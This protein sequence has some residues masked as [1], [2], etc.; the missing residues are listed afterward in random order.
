ML[1]YNSLEAIL[2][3]W[4]YACD[5]KH[6]TQDKGAGVGNLTPETIYITP[7]PKYFQQKGFP[8]YYKNLQKAL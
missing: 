3:T 1:N 2:Y 4:W 7:P 8:K 6:D 5:N